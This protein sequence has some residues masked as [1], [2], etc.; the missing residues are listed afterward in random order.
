MLTILDRSLLKEIWLS[1]SAVTCILLLIITGQLFVKLLNKTIEGQ[2]PLDTLLPLLGLVV[3]KAAIQLLPVSLL[4]GVMLALGRLYRDSEISALRACGV[5]YAQIYRALLLMAVPLVILLTG[6]VLHVLPVTVKTA[7]QI[8]YEA[9]AKTDISGISAG[10]FIESEQ[11]HWVVFAEFS[12]PK[13]RVLRNVFIHVLDAERIQV[14]TAAR[15][16]QYIDP[17]SGKRMLELQDGHLYEGFPLDGDYRLASFK[18]HTMPIPKLE[19]SGSPNGLD[20]LSTALLWRTVGAAHKA[21]LQRRISIPIS[22][23]LMVLVA[24]PLSYTN[25]RRGRFG[26][27]VVGI[28]VYI[29]YA[30]L[31]NL[32]VSLMENQSLPIWAGVW[33]AHLSMILF[34]FTLFIWQNGLRWSMGWLWRQKNRA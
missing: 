6:L 28:V 30:N 26:K 23:L 31:I 10:Q 34:I 2:L 15:A 9:K 4:L 7:D 21:E 13:N 1:F 17:V 16:I 3:V 11:G 25:P 19:D 5:S 14:E 27:L 22:A 20:T 18:K 8:E 12:D 32:S 29:I 24:L 33:W